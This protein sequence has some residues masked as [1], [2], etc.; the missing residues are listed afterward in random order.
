M[1]ASL[2]A[3]CLP[4]APL[5]ASGVGP[6]VI[7]VRYGGGVRRRETIAAGTSLSP[8]LRHHLIGRGTLYSDMRINPAPGVDTSHGQGTLHLLT[9]RYDPFENL[10]D[11][12]LGERFEPA[13]PT[14]FEYLRGAT[15]LPAHRVLMVNGEDRAQE[16]SMTFSN[17]ADYGAGLRAEMLSLARYKH[18]LARERLREVAADHPQRA[19]REQALAERQAQLDERER[20]LV[21]DPAVVRFWQRWRAEFGDHGLTNARGDRLLTQ[22]AL[23]A[24]VELQ[25]RLMMINY[26]DPDY[27]HWGN[28]SFYS[29]GIA[30]I[31]EGIRALVGAVDTLPAYR[32]NTCLVLVPDCGRDANPLLRIPYQHHFNSDEARRIWALFIGPG[33]A[34]GLEVRRPV[35][36]IDVHR[37]VAALL[38]V[39]APHA[40]G[41]FLHEVLA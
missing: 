31:D 8:F 14:L 3:A 13:A 19:A 25:P 22:L 37:T 23:R 26:Q 10:A 34:R 1:A 35:E 12:L 4:A 11:G 29:R 7:V 21:I 17:H 18:W 40:D 27:V 16:E 28:A 30:I 39:A 32:G 9:G 36:Q 2:A 33:V 24:L 15:G 20:G 5:R 6:N 38:G 41:E